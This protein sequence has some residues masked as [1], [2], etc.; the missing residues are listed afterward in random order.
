MWSDYL[1]NNGFLISLY[2]QMPILKNVRIMQFR[3]SCDKNNVELVFD[4][5][6]YADNPPEEWK[7]YK[8]NAVLVGIDFV[9]IN[10]LDFKFKS[11]NCIGNIDIFLDE[12]ELI[13]LKI[14][15]DINVNLLSER[16]LI[17]KVEAYCIR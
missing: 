12:N 11:E 9:S 10:T 4:M 16:A 3:I 14:T 6:V 8:C 1:S 2:T 13:H 15:G 5:P 7:K 17:Q